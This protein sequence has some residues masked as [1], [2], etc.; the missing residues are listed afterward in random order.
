MIFIK[1]LKEINLVAHLLKIALKDKTKLETL[2]LPDKNQLYKEF[3]N[4][5][6][7]WKLN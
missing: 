2:C 6:K 4:K 7:S 3:K 5:I 1:K